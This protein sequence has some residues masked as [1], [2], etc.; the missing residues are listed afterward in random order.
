MDLSMSHQGT[1][2]TL[3]SITHDYEAVH[4]ST[5]AEEAGVFKNFSYL[6]Q[7][8]SSRPGPGKLSSYS[9]MMR[10]NDELL[11]SHVMAGAAP[12]SREASVS[13][14]GG[15]TDNDT[16]NL[17][18]TTHTSQSELYS[19]MTSHDSSIVS[20]DHT[21]LYNVHNIKENSM[22]ELL[23]QKIILFDSNETRL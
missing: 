3:R 2:S 9:E 4:N 5:D 19:S 17:V 18:N 20:G 10:N 15:S 14:T 1:L 21:S 6:E 11:A 23:K 8:P 13:D 7:D 12:G 22:K 16:N